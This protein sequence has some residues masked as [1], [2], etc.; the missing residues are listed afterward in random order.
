MFGP[1]NTIGDE[2]FLFDRLIY[3]HFLLSSSNFL[4]TDLRA[5]VQVGR[6]L[7]LFYHNSQCSMIVN[8]LHCSTIFYLLLLG[9]FL[10]P[11]QDVLIFFQLFKIKSCKYRKKCI[12]I[13]PS[14]FNRWTI[15]TNMFQA[16]ALLRVLLSE[17]LFYH[18]S[19]V[20]IIIYYLFNKFDI[21]WPK[22]RGF[23]L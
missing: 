18:K 4:L 22:F 15:Q 8:F 16:C 5:F 12:Q 17:V 6:I 10:T 14:E 13:F 3:L 20:N 19:I 7:V 23:L 2:I 21:K 9:S 11:K 1:L